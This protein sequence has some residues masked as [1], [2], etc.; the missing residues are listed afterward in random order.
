L[1]ERKSAHAAGNLAGGIPSHAAPSDATTPTLEAVGLNKYFVKDGE[2]N[3]VLS[4]ISL[5]VRQ[6]EFAALI[7]PSGC[8]KSTFLK[9]VAGLERSDSGSVRVLGRQPGSGRFDVGFVFQHLALLPWRTVLGNV[10]LPAEFAGLR[11]DEARERAHEYLAMVGLRGYENYRL[12]EISGGMRQRVA[13]ARVLM[14][15]AKLLLLDEPFSA[16][17]E[18]TRETVDMLFMDVCSQTRA[19]AVLVTHS[20]HE[21]VLM[22]DRVFIMSA[23]P[24]H[25][26]DEVVVPIAR[27]RHPTV[28][29][30][31]VF[32]ETVNRV[33]SGLGLEQ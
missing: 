4:D 8:G 27:P 10:L 24:A 14:T 16:L 17:D 31:D 12:R 13:L 11:K 21:A 19:A 15:D 22:S 29:R 7:G 28:M 33:R 18:L 20:V 3:H 25:L 30:L 5:S 2:V 23:R 26:V 9:L 6:G 1:Q 32:T